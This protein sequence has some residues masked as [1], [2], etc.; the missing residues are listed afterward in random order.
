MTANSIIITSL[1]GQIYYVNPSTCS[2][3]GYKENE[4]NG[5]HI[6]IIFADPA[7][8]KPSV[9]KR[10]ENL[11][12]KGEMKN[13][14]KSYFAKNGSEV[15]INLSIS[16][17]RRGENIQYIVYEAQNINSIKKPEV[18]SLAAKKA[19][20]EMRNFKSEFLANMS[21]EIRTPITSI[22]GMTDLILKTGLNSQQLEYIGMLQNSTDT[23]MSLINDILDFS[24][25][26]A[27]RLAL[28]FRQFNLM[29]CIDSVLNTVSVSAKKKGLALFCF[30]SPDVP[31]C[32]VG[33]AARLRRVLLNLLTNAIKFTDKGEI[34]LNVRNIISPPAGSLS[35]IYEMDIQQKN[36]SKESPLLQ[37]SWHSALSSLISDCALQFS[38]RD[39]GI[40]IPP[41]KQESI[42]EPF[43]QVDSSF[44]RRYSGAGL[45]LSISLGL[46]KLMGGKFWV[47][48]EKEKGNTFHFTA[49][50]GLS[51]E[52]EV[53]L[54]NASDI[55]NI[56]VLVMDSN[57]RDKVT[58]VETLES[59]GITPTVVDNGSA[60]IEEMFH[61]VSVNS[62]YKILLLNA[63]LPDIN[64]FA[65]ISEIKKSPMFNKT[66][67]V[68]LCSSDPWYDRARFREIGISDYLT[69]PIK[70]SDL[71]NK[72]MN[73]STTKVSSGYTVAKTQETTK[74]L[75][76][77][78][79]LDVLLVEDNAVNQYLA[80][81]FLME[82]GHYVK[83]VNNGIEAV[84]ALDK[85]E[86]DL[87]LMDV[88]MP[89]MDGF[90]ATKTIREKEMATN[91]HIPIIAMT[92]IAM[93]GDRQ[94]CLD[95]GMDEYV[96]K[97]IYRD[98][99][100]R[101]INNV[102]KNYP[103]FVSDPNKEVMDVSL[104]LAG[105]QGNNKL[106]K[107]IAAMFLNELPNYLSAIQEAVQQGDSYKLERA[108]HTF[109]GAVGNFAAKSTFAAVYAIEMIGKSGDMTGVETA[110]N[111]L[112]KEIERLNPML[113]KIS[114]GELP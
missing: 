94:R 27:D 81:S 1:E 4:L 13:L 102:M 74:S 26:E 19:S 17:I 105:L 96:S 34:T 30:V 2:L 101:T 87:I 45:G 49:Q 103:S 98:E 57:V 62:P 47:E 29:E 77:S 79:C 35:K 32:L 3:L 65:L 31:V 56:R 51:S 23:L 21:H 42:F 8:T 64:V 11:F 75:V 52:N 92:A 20:E 60:V 70:K 106:L 46:V 12:V 63:S 83:V 85:D 78:R 58:L 22:M 37:E 111:Q 86:Y 110:I 41:S 71:L 73:L 113:E 104:A 89:I 61:A 14:K 99:L 82:A 38:V 114:K 15:A 108:S 55:R 59:F 48:S 109:K 54:A 72:I 91:K 25:I 80:I 68:M 28:D 69:K 6:G 40:V 9:E 100:L 24:E 36:Y 76:A 7:E 97:P 93:K 88:H 95:A 53:V 5:Q 90:Q 43:V 44:S 66:E 67:V 33:D 16:F 112:M 84:N 39:T 50:F 10:G 107:D 18:E